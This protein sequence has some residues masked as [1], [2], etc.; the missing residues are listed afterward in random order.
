MSLSDKKQSSQQTSQTQATNT[1]GYQ[2]P[3]S[4]PD[5]DKL[6]GEKF[7]VDPGLDAQ[8]GSLR[9]QVDKSA[10]N[11]LGPSYNPQVAEQQ[12]KSAMERLG[13]DEAQ[14]YRG[15]QYDANKLNFARDST[16]AGMSAPQLTQTG[17]S[18]TGS[19]SGTT[20]QSTSPWSGIASTGASLAPLS[21]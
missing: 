19:G 5:L 14:A 17:S 15:G 8:Y 18:S 1:Y 11:P 20:V 12:R 13:Q 2:T 16:V 10:H 6:R 3:P 9:S 7:T 4:T 21:L